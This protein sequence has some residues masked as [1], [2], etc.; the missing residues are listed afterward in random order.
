M[1]LPFRQDL[2]M[3]TEKQP[4]LEAVIRKR[5]VK[6]QVGKDLAVCSSDL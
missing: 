3:E 2:S 4:L 5:L 1:E 6:A